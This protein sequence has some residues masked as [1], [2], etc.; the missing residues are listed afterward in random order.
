[1]IAAKRKTILFVAAIL[2][3]SGTAY[4]KLHLRTPDGRTVAVKGGTPQ[5][6]LSAYRSPLESKILDHRFYTG[7]SMYLGNEEYLMGQVGFWEMVK[8]GLPVAYKPAFHWITHQEAYWYA[9]Y[10][11]DFVGAQAHMGVSMVHG[12]YW[13]L[14]ARELYDKNRFERDR[15]ER[16]FGNKDVLMGI[17]LPMFYKRT[18]FPRV[19]EF[20][21]PSYLDYASGDPRFVG[22]V[23]VEDDFKDPMS[24]KKGNWGA[25]RYWIDWSNSRWDHDSMDVTFDLGAIGQG[26]KRRSLWIG[27]MLKADHVEDSPSVKGEQV[28]LLG[29]DAEEGFRGITLTFMCANMMLAAKAELFA[30]AQGKK[31]GG[32]NPLTY[33]PKKGIRYLPHQ[34]HPNLI[35]IGDIPERLWALDDIPDNSS[36]LWDIASWIWGTT[37][38]YYRAYK[39]PQVFSANPPVDGGIIEKNT[40]LLARGLASVM[41]KNMEAMHRKS[42]VLVSEWTPKKGT[43]N[44]VSLQDSAMAVV[45][46]ADYHH[47]LQYGGDPE[48]KLREKAVEMLTAQADFLLKVQGEDGSFYEKYDV[49]TGKGIGGNTL[50]TPQWQGIRTLV[51]AY[52]V[53]EEEKYLRAA[54]KTFNLL[55]REYWHEGSGLYRTRLGDDTVI[56][57]PLEVG[58]AVGAMREMMFATPLH[59]VEPQMER[60]T[61][62]WVQTVNTSGLQQAEDNKSGELTY[63]KKNKDEDADGVPFISGG[64]GKYGCAPVPAGKMAVNL[65]GSGNKA[66]AELKGEKHVPARFSKVAYAYNPRSRN[67]QLALLLPLEIKEDGL[68]KREPLERFDGQIIPLPASRPIERGLG[69]KQ[70]L[71]GKQIFEVNC[72]LCHGVKGEGI[73]GKPLKEMSTRRSEEIKAVPMSGRFEKGMPPWGVGVDQLAGVLTEE[74]IDRVVDY[75]QH[76]LFREDGAVAQRNGAGK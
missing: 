28:T 58:A 13:T 65:G 36:Q 15:G 7:P 33:D 21:N 11:L 29:N 3:A 40:S 56:L 43:G 25:P 64:H 30:D 19:F 47:L 20:A 22:P 75:I 73:T 53:T 71:T 8:A 50:S 16:V 17:Y 9:R 5:P 38:Y 10:I 1:M 70:N 51:A 67:E 42:G 23:I 37:D 49:T 55:N 45:A 68:V 63:G 27:Y 60:F 14:K 44:V 32:I 39:Y 62:W 41:V 48:P 31:L 4:A 57:T 72:S 61:R 26:L 6:D 69:I 76:G 54:R 66:F 46:L 52:H 12:P 24:G 18:G 34:V 35:V 59:L 74:E 2:L